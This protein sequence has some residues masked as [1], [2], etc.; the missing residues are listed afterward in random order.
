MATHRHVCACG[1]YFVCSQEPDKCTVRQ[2]ECP[3]CVD[4]QLDAWMAELILNSLPQPTQQEQ[5]HAH[6]GQ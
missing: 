2:F 3:R 1:D 5:E 6:E 4:A